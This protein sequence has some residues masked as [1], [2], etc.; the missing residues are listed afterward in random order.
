MAN[1]SLLICVMLAAALLGEGQAFEQCGQKGS[2]SRRRRDGDNRIV[3]GQDAGHGE[4][5]WQISLQ[6]SPFFLIPKQH[7]CGGTLIAKNWVLSAAHCFMQSKTASNYG[8]C[9]ST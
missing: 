4:F 1:L 8:W 2:V 9:N 5:P 7:L 3:N 6:Y